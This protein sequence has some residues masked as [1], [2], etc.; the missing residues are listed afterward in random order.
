VKALVEKYFGTLRRG[1]PVPPIEAE[2]PRITA[3][4]R[5]VVAAR[6]ELPRVY[7]AWITPRI[8]QPGDADADIAATILGGGRTSRLYKALVYDKQVAQNVRALQ[9]SLML[10]SIFQIE[11]TA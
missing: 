8:F 7:M 11:V 2:T 9:Y 5:K 10:G 1:P 6:V 4:R 3:E